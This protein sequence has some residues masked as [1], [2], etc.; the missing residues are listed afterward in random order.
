MQDRADLH[1]H[2]TASDGIM[3]PT[4]IVE[5]A[6]RLGIGAVAIT[7]HDTVDGLAEATE[8][9]KCHSVQFI[10]GIEI[11][12]DYGATEVHII[13]YFIDPTHEELLEA[14]K[15]LREARSDRGELMVR[16]LRDIGVN[17]T[18]DRVREIAG[19]GSIGRPHVAKAI[20]EAGAAS[21]MNSAFGKYLI[22]GKPAFVPRGRLKAVEAIQIVLA[23][24]GVPGLGHPGKVGWD[25]II[26]ELKAAGLR[27][28]EV[29]HTD[30]SRHESKR[31]K[32]LAEEHG[33]IPTGGSDS[34]G[35]T[36]DKPIAIGSVTVDVE[37]VEQLRSAA[38][39]NKTFQQ[40]EQD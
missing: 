34:H 4:E 14:L 28:L 39:R 35:M 29:Y 38:C 40:D 23:A 13:G 2:S 7:D 6:A 17:V 30:H 16:K 27:A 18:M 9:A 10:P 1:I 15:G 24:G 32:K 20:C 11:N 37:V 33:L 26:P 22:R 19:Y 36:N 25:G 8:A 31:Y 12:T 21:G 5:E 3:T